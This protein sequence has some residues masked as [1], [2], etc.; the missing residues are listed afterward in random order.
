MFRYKKI[1]G[2]DI[3]NSKIPSE[4]QSWHK[5][6]KILEL[7]YSMN[8]IDEYYCDY[9]NIMTLLVSDRQEQY[10]IELS[11]YNISGDFNFNMA[12][13][14]G[15]GFAIDEFSDSGIEKIFHLYSFEQ[16]MKYDL[17]CEKIRVVLL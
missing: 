13:G 5:F 15:S 10:K 9:T 4:L 11:L 8:S 6:F 14:L 3:L 16:D 1:E 17:Y 12:N 7:K 2:I